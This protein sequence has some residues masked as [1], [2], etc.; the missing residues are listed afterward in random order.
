MQRNEPFPLFAI[1]NP[2]ESWVCDQ[3]DKLLSEW[4][5]WKSTCENFP[6]SAEFDPNT[7]TEAIKDGRDNLNR[8]EILREKTLVFM[9]NNFKGS[10]FVLDKWP[11]HPHE[12]VTSRLRRRVPGWIH[13]LEVLKA[14][15]EYVHISDEVWI[16]R[17]KFLIDAVNQA[18]GEEVLELTVDVLKNPNPKKGR[19][20]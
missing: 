11:S 6:D 10:E 14:S 5:N 2:N 1:T 16:S 7:C 12:D 20:F 18:S 9:R 8:H 15:M 3:L 17:A 13:R 4:T 19:K